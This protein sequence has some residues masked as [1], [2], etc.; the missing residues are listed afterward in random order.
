LLV[1]FNAEFNCDPNLT[2]AVAEAPPSKTDSAAA[3]AK[4]EAGRAASARVKAIPNSMRLF[5]CNSSP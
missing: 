2:V 3:W 5:I 4:A 1:W